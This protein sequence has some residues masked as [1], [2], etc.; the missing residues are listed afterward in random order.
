MIELGNEKL[1]VGLLEWMNRITKENPMI[2]ETDNDD[3]VAMY[4]QSLLK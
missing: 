2:L 4:L 1:C 3:I